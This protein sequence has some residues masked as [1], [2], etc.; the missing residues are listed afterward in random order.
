MFITF[1]G[2]DG[3]GKTTQLRLL[4]AALEEKGHT[5]CT[6]R[7]PGGTSIGNA[8]RNILLDSANMEMTPQAE[9]LL[10]N[11]AR[12][13]L[14]EEVIRPA[15]AQGCRTVLQRVRLPIKGMAGVNLSKRCIR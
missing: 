6:T 7:E 12:A 2:P 14:I 4:A 9:A 1:E 13:Q 11:A 3:G 15:I 5:V 10:F 8:V